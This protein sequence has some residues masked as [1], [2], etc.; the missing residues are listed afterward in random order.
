MPHM[1]LQQCIVAA[2]FQTMLR[3]SF[4]CLP[5]NVAGF[6]LF[7]CLFWNAVPLWLLLP[8][9]ALVTVR[10]AMTLRQ[11]IGLYGNDVSPATQEQV[12]HERSLYLV[13]SVWIAAVWGLA[14]MLHLSP[15][16]AYL[17][18]GVTGFL[19]L[20]LTTYV[21]NSPN[22]IK[23]VL[24]AVGVQ[25]GLAFLLRGDIPGLAATGIFVCVAYLMHFCFSRYIAGHQDTLE[26][27]VEARI[28]LESAAKSERETARVANTD[29]LTG[30]PNRRAF[31][32]KV[33]DLITE[34]GESRDPFVVGVLDLNGFKPVNDCFG[35]AAGDKLLVEV[36]KR[37]VSIIGYAGA[38]ARLGGD[39]FGILV[40][41]AKAIP[42]LATL[43]DDLVSHVT[44]PLEIDGPVA[45]VSASCGLAV[46]PDVA[47]TAA[48]LLECANDARVR[49]KASL[50]RVA[51]FNVEDQQERIRRA[52]I[53][54]RLRHAVQA[55]QISLAYQPIVCLKT[56]RTLSREALSRWND[57]ILGTVSPGEFIPAAERCGLIND[58]CRNTAAKATRD[59][60]TWPAD[61]GVSINIAATRFADPCFSSNLVSALS[62]GGLAPWRLTLEITESIFLAD[63]YNA[64][65][66]L[67]QLCSL[68]IRVALDDFG[69]GYASFSYLDRFPFD[70]LKLDRSL[71][72]S[73]NEQ[74]REHIVAAIVDMCRRLG[75]TCVAE[76]IETEAQL[77]FV[78]D[79]GCDAAQGF[80]LGRPMANEYLMPAP[81]ARQLIEA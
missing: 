12:V 28:Q 31:L 55:N 56:G 38:V 50:S 74:R 8:V 4:V 61:Q 48:T 51:T 39:A 47:T 66:T 78:R 13:V 2:Q 69:A 23:W 49:A 17:M 14:V 7:V 68:G 65:A 15:N 80:L 81:A 64:S 44:L 53:E 37:L 62:N 35:H 16:Q 60:A 20:A 22:A 71:I 73:A 72:V 11:Y 41:D 19:G 21:A 45:Q 32:A 3:T 70:I 30:L 27:E 5:V 29:A 57:D 63:N 59:A 9:P 36:G 34:R 40:T 18:A 76:G 75:M 77:A 10:C 43:G 25:M 24:T 54:Q 58:L 42:K 26:R 33:N 52:T 6:L 46:F 1:T 79:I 67:E